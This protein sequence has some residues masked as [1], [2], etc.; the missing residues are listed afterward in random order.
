MTQTFPE[1]VEMYGKC[2]VMQQ[3]K[4]MESN[5]IMPHQSHRMSAPSKDRLCRETMMMNQTLFSN[6]LLKL[7][8]KDQP[9]HHGES[10]HP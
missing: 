10:C 7:R 2:P 5:C 4:E 8:G 1:L 9:P 3:K 6:Q